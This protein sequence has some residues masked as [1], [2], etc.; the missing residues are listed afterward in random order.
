MTRPVRWAGE[1][2]AALP[3][4]AV[5]GVEGDVQER[6]FLQGAGHAQ[7]SGVDGPQA[8]RGQQVRHGGLGL[9]VVTGVEAV[10]RLPV[11]AGAGQPR[12][13]HGVERL[14]QLRLRGD[15]G[16]LLGLAGAGSGQVAV[17]VV[18][19]VGDVHDNRSGDG[20]AELTQYLGGGAGRHRQNDDVGAADGLGRGGRGGGA[21]L[22]GHLHRVLRVCGG[23]RDIVPCGGGRSGQATADVA[24]SDDRN[25]HGVLLARNSSILNQM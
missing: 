24:R 23:E 15:G 14:D 20:V 21:G 22:L 16:Q 18:E 4:P 8:E 5:A 1:L 13:E 6:Q 11:R 19:R 9:L 17:G 25:T 7:A 10:Q 3:G 2:P 12:G